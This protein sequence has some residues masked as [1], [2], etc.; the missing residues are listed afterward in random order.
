MHPGMSQ[1]RRTSVCRGVRLS[2]AEQ[3]AL[4][5]FPKGSSRKSKSK[6]PELVIT[7]GNRLS[8]GFAANRPASA[9]N[10]RRST[11]IQTPTGCAG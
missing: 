10:D 8:S 6:N 5:K 4:A 7:G 1:E 9:G 3:A 11:P 2:G